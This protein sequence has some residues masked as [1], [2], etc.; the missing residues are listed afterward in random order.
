MH[1]LKRHVRGP[2][3]K[4]ETTL[5]DLL[6]ENRVDELIHS[7]AYEEQPLTSH[8]RN[9]PDG[10][11][12]DP[13][14]RMLGAPVHLDAD[15]AVLRRYLEFALDDLLIQDPDGDHGWEDGDHG[16]PDLVWEEYSYALVAGTMSLTCAGPT[17]HRSTCDNFFLFKEARIDIED[18]KPLEPT[19]IEN[20]D[21]EFI[22]RDYEHMVDDYLVSSGVFEVRNLQAP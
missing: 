15:S 18:D 13:T 17:E 5:L 9:L 4:C 8:H 19:D 16:R 3:H 22:P 14:I 20:N 10:H 11:G 6:L 1:F 7:D 2:L 12:G 21:L